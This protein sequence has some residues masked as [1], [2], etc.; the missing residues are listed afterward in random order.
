MLSSHFH[1]QKVLPAIRKMK[2]LEHLM[3]S[4]FTTLVL[5]DS[6]IA[7]LASIGQLVRKHRKQLLVHVDLINGLKND[8]YAIEFVCQT[9]RPA[10]IISTRS[11]AVMT[12]KKHKILGIQRHFLLDSTALEMTYKLSDKIKPDFIEVM[13]GIMP[14]IIAEMRKRIDIPILAGGLIRTPGDVD[15][16]LASGAVAVTSSLKELWNAFA[17]ETPKAQD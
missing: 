2:D 4:S 15:L 13:P 9:M 10:G 8:D 14:H 5:L 6:H 12:A 17:D 3:S 11:S 7:Q 1:G 16:A